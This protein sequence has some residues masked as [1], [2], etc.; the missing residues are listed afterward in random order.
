M[1]GRDA[2]FVVTMPVRLGFVAT[3]RVYVAEG[4]CSPL[5]LWSMGARVKAEDERI[6]GL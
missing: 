6:L 2:V 3:V 4:R 1:L 5:E